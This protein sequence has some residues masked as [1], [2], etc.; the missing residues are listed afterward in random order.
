MSEV[1]RTLS[2]STLDNRM[3]TP[4]SK[5][6]TYE[7]VTYRP[8]GG[9]ARTV[10]LGNVKVSGILLTGSEVDESGETR[11]FDKGT[12]ERIH[13]IDTGC[14]LARVPLVVDN[15]YALLVEA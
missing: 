15:T 11:W 9:K 5:G 1:G 4:Y 3:G 13:V 12:T 14:I 6:M 8:E 7:R 10:V 2:R